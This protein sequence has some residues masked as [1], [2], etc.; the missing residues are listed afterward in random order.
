[1]PNI[2]QQ[3]RTALCQTFVQ[4]GPDAPTLCGD[5]TT[6]DLAAHLVLRE[7]RPD[8]ALG[9]ILPALAGHTE[10]VQNGIA[11]GNWP[12]LVE[13]VLDGPPRWHP[14]AIDKID[15]ASNTAEFFVHHEDVLRGGEGWEP[16]ELTP[17]LAKGLWA[18]LPQIGRLALRKV[19]VGVVADCPGVGR[20]SIKK[21]KSGHGS[22]V[23][24][25]GP[26]EVL[27]SI[28][29]RDAVAQVTFDGSDA[30]VESYKNA[31][32]GV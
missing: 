10:K 14:A 32:R 31:G 24:S 6:R 26:G 1:M 23:I 11:A 9:A 2:A 8:A 27:L 20:R 21:P 15:V 12:A 29:G 3:E 5:W 13:K 28:F 4:V 19:P 18:A 17:Q 25:G 7:R 30:E 22:V 16:R